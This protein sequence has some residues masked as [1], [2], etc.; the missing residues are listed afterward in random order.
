MRDSTFENSELPKVGIVKITPNVTKEKLFSLRR[1]YIGISLD[2]PVFYNSSL[3]AILKWGA[4]KFEQCLIVLGDYLRRHNE[5]IF[6]G[7]QGPV[8]EKASFQ[9]GDEYI[10]KTR[11]IFAQ[12]TEPKLTLIKWKDCLGWPQY[13]TSKKI[14]DNLYNNDDTFRAV[15]QKDAFAF[16]K[17]QKKRNEDL[18]VPM[19]K[20]IDISSEYLLEEIAAFSA[21]SERGWNVE[22]YPGPELCV[23]VDIAQ[24]DF[25]D[26][27]KGLKDRVNVQLR[28]SK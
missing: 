8:A 7:L 18:S 3:T 20:A 9:A 10:E 12:F 14:L 22:L 11:E 27:P 2:N 17:R 15:V 19:E 24:G 21:L 13:S 16:I 25:S 1:C 5:Y 26:I 23:L 6:N 28:V 4:E